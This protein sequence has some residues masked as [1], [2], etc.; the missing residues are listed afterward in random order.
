MSSAVGDGADCFSPRMAEAVAAK[1]RGMFVA[2][3]KR[4][5]DLQDPHLLLSFRVLS[6]FL[7]DGPSL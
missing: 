4:S 5:P 2:S 7:S 3:G 6:A 1:R